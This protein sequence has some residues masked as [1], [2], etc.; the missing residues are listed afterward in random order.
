M[1]QAAVVLQVGGIS[2][3]AR[4]DIEVRQVR[5][6][7]QSE[8]GKPGFAVQPRMAQGHGRKG[9]GQVIHGGSENLKFQN[10]IPRSYLETRTSTFK[11]QRP[12]FENGKKQLE[13][14][15]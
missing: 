10:E 1:G 13:L 15:I 8:S 11:I 3:K 9:M 7:D 14:G 2:P 12:K 5:S 4:E 6:H